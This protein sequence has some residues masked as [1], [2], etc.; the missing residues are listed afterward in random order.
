V[1]SIAFVNTPRAP[2][3]MAFAV[4]IFEGCLLLAN[5]EPR[6]VARTDG[7]LSPCSRLSRVHS[8]VHVQ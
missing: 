3:V 6:Q 1:L 7:A 2:C 5:N 4:A 8:A